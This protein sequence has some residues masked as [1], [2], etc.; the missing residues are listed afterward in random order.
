MVYKIKE[1]GSHQRRE[2][3]KE[4]GDKSLRTKDKEK[5]GDIWKATENKKKIK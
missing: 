3:S 1:L 2:R 4:I 5:G